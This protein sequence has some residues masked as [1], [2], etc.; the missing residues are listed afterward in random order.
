MDTIIKEDALLQLKTNIIF[1]KSHIHI[2]NTYVILECSF[3]EFLSFCKKNNIPII[4]YEYGV[5]KQDDYIVT[6]DL[7]KTLTNNEGEYEFCKKWSI[8]YNET[9][10]QYDFSQPY[11]L[12][13][14]A[15]LNGLIL[16][17]SAK[18]YW[19]PE[20][21]KKADDA[22]ITY[23]EEHED[24]LIDFYKYDDSTAISNPYKE[25]ETILLSDKNFRLCTNVQRRG[26][27]FRD[28]IKHNQNKKFLLLF[29]TAKSNSERE[30]R[31][32]NLFDQIYTEYRNSCYKLK[33]QLGDPLPKDM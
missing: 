16:G 27:Y 8:E 21:I 19:L 14:L 22:L 24:E 32:Q 10:R 6:Q 30:F 25:L 15:S 23:M 11:Q 29:R 33:I 13:M 17:Y 7:L 12:I 1:I 18:N 26:V 28:F 3:P 31:L 20:N 2:A 9:I 4:F 5:Y